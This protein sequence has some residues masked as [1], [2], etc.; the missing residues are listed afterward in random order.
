MSGLLDMYTQGPRATGPR[1]EGI[2]IR[3]TTNLYGITGMCHIA[4]HLATWKPRCEQFCKLINCIFI[5]KDFGINCGF[6]LTE[7]FNYTHLRKLWILISF[8]HCKVS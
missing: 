3:Q 6:S 4:P 1:A 2:H 5:G 8:L 7:T